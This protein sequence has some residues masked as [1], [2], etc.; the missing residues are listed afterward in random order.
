MKSLVHKINL[1]QKSKNRQLMNEVKKK[2]IV[3]THVDEALE[4]VANL[5]EMILVST[6]NFSLIIYAVQETI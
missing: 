2:N 5:E 3:Q 1:F 6:N 4:K